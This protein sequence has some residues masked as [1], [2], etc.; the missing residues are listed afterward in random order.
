MAGPGS[1]V[2]LGPVVEL[3]ET[4]AAETPHG[5]RGFTLV[6]VDG[7]DGSGKTTFAGT[8][9]AA[10]RAHGRP[11][12]VVHADDFLNLREVRHRRGRASPEGFWLD[13]YDYAALERC[14]LAPFGPQG[15]GVY[16]AASSDHR[17]DVA[18]D[19]PPVRARRGTVCVVEGMFLHRGELAGRWDYSVFLHVPFTE[20]A[21]RMALRDGSPG[22][23][24]HPAMRRYV[25][26]QRLYF[27]DSSP[28]LRATRV[29]D[30]T[31]PAA[32]FF[33]SSASA[34]PTLKTRS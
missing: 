11:V 30:N 5:H 7:V 24:E 10:L 14:V 12:V 1:V 17:L 6:A 4:L 25:R 16:R 28:W 34:G 9:A 32:P 29:V 21:R 18:V 15:N 2:E 33:A 19:S 31:D 8:Y 27:A 22:D 23:P 3:V 26:G 20:T 13:T